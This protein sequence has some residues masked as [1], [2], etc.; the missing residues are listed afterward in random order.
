MMVLSSG[1]E[2]FMKNYFLTLEWETIL[3]MSGT[4]H[5]TTWYHIPEEW[6]PQQLRWFKYATVEA[7]VLMCY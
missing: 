6:R 4:S 3:T 7:I 2:V 1:V 5:L